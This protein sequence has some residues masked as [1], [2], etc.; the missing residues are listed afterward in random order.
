VLP[1]KSFALC[2]KA[3]EN[4]H[5]NATEDKYPDTCKKIHIHEEGSSLLVFGL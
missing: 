1:P 4:Y 3:S 5:G 2:E